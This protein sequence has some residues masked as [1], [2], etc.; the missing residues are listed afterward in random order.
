MYV[1]TN[2]EQNFDF[3]LFLKGKDMPLSKMRDSSSS[4][5]ISIFVL[6][7]IT[8]KT[9]NN[10]WRVIIYRNQIKDKYV[11]PT[12]TPFFFFIASCL[13]GTSCSRKKNPFKNDHQLSTLQW[14]EG[15]KNKRL[16]FRIFIFWSK[17]SHHRMMTM[18]SR[19][20]QMNQFQRLIESSY[21]EDRYFF[22]R[23]Y[24]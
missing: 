16:K 24:N 12:H 5:I 10:K 15:R 6:I 1:R 19:L 2:L 22:K 9:N 4:S 21:W 3:F 13:V 23:I 8:L 17:N 14:K 20:I 7:K 11:R 18:S